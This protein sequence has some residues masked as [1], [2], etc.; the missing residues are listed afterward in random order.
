MIVSEVQIICR[1][2]MNSRRLVAQAIVGFAIE[3]CNNL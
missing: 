2:G 3:K 1:H